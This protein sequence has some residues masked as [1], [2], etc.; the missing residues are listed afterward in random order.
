M[1]VDIS[2]NMNLEK[3]AAV[4]VNLQQSHLTVFVDYRPQFVAREELD[5]P[6]VL[7]IWRLLLVDKF[8]STLHLQITKMQTI[9]EDTAYKHILLVQREVDYVGFYTLGVQGNTVDALET[10]VEHPDG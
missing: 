1:V 5:L 7:V 2:D 3:S 8:H 6:A 4:V 9:L 10:A